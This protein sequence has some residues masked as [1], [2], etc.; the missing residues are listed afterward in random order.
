MTLYEY[1]RR[2]SEPIPQWLEQFN[3]GEAFSSEQFF[4]S[5]IIYY[6]GPRYDGQPVKLFGSTHSAHSFVYVDYGLTKDAIEAELGHDEYGFRGYHTL[7][8]VQL[9]ERDLTPN[10]W[11][12]HVDPRYE[13]PHGRAHIHTD[14][15]GFIEVLE[16]D[17]NLDDNYGAPLI[18]IMFLG[19][20]GIAA[21]DALFCQQNGTPPPFAFVLQDH[22]FGGNYDRFGRGGLLENIANRCHAVPRWLLVADKTDPWDGFTR[23]PDVDGEPGGMYGVLHFLYEQCDDFAKTAG[24]RRSPGK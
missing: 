21:Y 22:G 10:G 7:D 12:D 18:G 19:A 15:F 3:N 8:R 23:V 11:V 16:R 2:I 6:P 13:A 9:A 4:A 1:L 20:D 14:P 5:R 17:Q 24:V